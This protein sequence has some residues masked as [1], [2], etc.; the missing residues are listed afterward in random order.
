MKYAMNKVAAAVISSNQLT[1]EINII[2][3]ARIIVLVLNQ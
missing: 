3:A 1:K 2:P